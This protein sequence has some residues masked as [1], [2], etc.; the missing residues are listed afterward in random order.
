MEAGDVEII[1]PQPVNI[2]LTS[3]GI[4]FVQIIRFQATPEPR[5][6]YDF[7]LSSPLLPFP[8]RSSKQ[9]EQNLHLIPGKRG[10]V[11]VNTTKFSR[12]SHPVP[13][14]LVSIKL[15]LRSTLQISSTLAESSGFEPINHY[16]FRRKHLTGEK[17][18]QTKTLHVVAKKTEKEGDLLKRKRFKSEGMM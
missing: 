17:K 3:P 6:S 10:H 8:I 5:W 1:F 7:S 2:V 4:T 12:P 11:N 16:V 15:A 18:N 9:Y 14:A 13:C